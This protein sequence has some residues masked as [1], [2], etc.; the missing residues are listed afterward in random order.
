[1]R[2]LGKI[3]HT[4]GNCGYGC[5]PVWNPGNGRERRKSR[6]A[7]RRKERQTFRQAYSY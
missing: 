6:R 1:M 5:C 2:M 3:A 7:Q 4:D